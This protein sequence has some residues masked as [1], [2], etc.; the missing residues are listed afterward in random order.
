MS[1]DRHLSFPA[2]CFPPSPTHIID[3][4]DP[5]F[6]FACQSP[7]PFEYEAN[8]FAD[9]PCNFY[10]FALSKFQGDDDFLENSFVK[11]SY[12]SSPPPQPSSEPDSG[13]DDCADSV[14][15]R[16]QEV[17]RR[18]KTIAKTRSPELTI[19]ASKIKLRG[20]GCLTSNCLR[21]YCKCFS[22]QGYC[23]EGCG[24]V[25]CFNTAEYETERQVVIVKTKEICRTSFTPK[26]LQTESG[27]K[28]NAEGCRCKSGCKSQHCLC[29]KNGVGCSPICRC[30]G[31]VNSKVNLEPAEV[32]KYYRSPLRTKDKI[33]IS[34]APLGATDE[35]TVEVVSPLAGK[36]TTVVF[37]PKADSETRISHCHSNFASS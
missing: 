21:R 14:S 27:A 7:L 8:P 12:F 20:C 25:D 19:S 24:C 1:E 23:S 35:K 10:Q 37:F 29:S 9:E 30:E 13:S 32:R 4:S 36:K 17:R 22:G 31:C 5:P 33:L 34:S 2:Y 11:P 28:I 26:I 16:T 3:D 18:H 6:Q 15:P